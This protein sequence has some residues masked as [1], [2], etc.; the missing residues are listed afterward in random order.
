MAVVGSTRRTVLAA[1][2]ATLFVGALA[3][4]PNVAAQ[5]AAPTEF[6]RCTV[7]HSTKKGGPEKLGPSLVGIY[8]APAGGG[9]YPYSPALK[10]SKIRWNDAAL[11]AWLAR[12]SKM[13]PGNKMAF[14]GMSDPA[15]RKAII[16]YMRTLK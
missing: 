15:K 1:I 9:K 13:V 8:G 6:A 5:T 4:T 16:L 12:P 10:A 3:P 7:C 2:T 11:D 14:P